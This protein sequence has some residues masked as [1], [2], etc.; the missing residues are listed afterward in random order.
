MFQILV[1]PKKLLGFVNE[2]YLTYLVGD[3]LHHRVPTLVTE[4]FQG[5]L[6]RR[7]TVELVIFEGEVMIVSE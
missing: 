3:M 5:V 4:C 2:P 6:R 1:L 7:I